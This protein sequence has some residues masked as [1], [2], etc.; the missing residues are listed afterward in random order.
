MNI[1]ISDNSGK[2]IWITPNIPRKFTK[3]IAQ[4]ERNLKWIIDE[5][6]SEYSV[7]PRSTA[8]IES[9]NH[10]TNLLHLSFP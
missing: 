4:G 2:K 1:K 9:V 6:K 8:D 7:A 5:G 10:P 3:E